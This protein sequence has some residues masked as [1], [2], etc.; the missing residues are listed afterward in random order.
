MQ[1]RLLDVRNR[2]A[3]GGLNNSGKGNGTAVIWNGSTTAPNWTPTGAPNFSFTTAG[4][5]AVD[6]SMPGATVEAYTVAGAASPNAV[7][8]S[9]IGR[10]NYTTSFG[11]VTRLAV[12]QSEVGG[13]NQVA[14]D[15]NDVY[16]ASDTQIFLAGTIN[17]GG[18]PT[19]SSVAFYGGNSVSNCDGDTGFTGLAYTASPNQTQNMIA[20]INTGA[21]PPVGQF[22]A[23]HG[24]SASNVM[25]GGTA[26]TLFSY[27]GSTWTQQVPS[28]TGLTNAYDVR[29]IYLTG[30]EAWVAGEVNYSIVVANCRAVFVLHGVQ[31]AGT[32]T[33]NKLITMTNDYTTC[34]TNL[35]Y[36]SVGH[37]W[38]DGVTGSVY[39]VGAT[40]TNVAGQI[41]AYNPTQE[42]QAVLRVKTQ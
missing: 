26:G 10:T 31:S 18:T 13:C 22:R 9:N 8:L 21:N 33:W 42:R 27:N 4:L 39:V 29:S 19:Q 12:A 17:N 7:I 2:L 14:L 24:T 35:D 41:P 3:V 11:P 28:A 6:M 36:T 15:I 23:V 32:W 37:I 5:N 16:Q 1:S 38:V 20:T 34:G 25:V 30:N 40:G